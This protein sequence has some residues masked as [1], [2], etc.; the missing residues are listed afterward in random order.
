MLSLVSTLSMSLDTRR[1][2]CVTR[3][4]F[5]GK[6]QQHRAKNLDNKLFATI[7]PFALQS[8][9]LKPSLNEPC[10]DEV[11]IHKI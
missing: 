3:G 10:E 4:K 2:K 9:R 5:I 1:K 6:H 7:Y 8:H 11:S